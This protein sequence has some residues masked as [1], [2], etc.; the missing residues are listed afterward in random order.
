MTTFF[1]FPLV[2]LL[3]LAGLLFIVISYFKREPESKEAESRFLVFIYFYA[4]LLVSGFLVFWGSSLIIKSGFAYEF[5]IPFSYRGEAR[6]LEPSRISAPTAPEVW[7]DVKTIPSSPPKIEY[8]QNVREKDL[9]RGAMFLIFGLLF[10]FAHLKTM[11]HAVKD[12]VNAFLS[13]SYHLLGALTYGGIAL[14][15]FPLAIYNLLERL[16]FKES[17]TVENLFQMEFPGELLGYAIPA[18]VIWY[19]FFNKV[20]KKEI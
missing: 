15:T 8:P 16:L 18:L 11:R 10:F 4:V 20:I 17:I 3:V 12:A 2:V 13:K 6:Y 7:K 1:I 9:L 5:G 19:F 14:V